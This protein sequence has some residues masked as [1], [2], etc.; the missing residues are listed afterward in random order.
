MTEA[1]KPINELPSIEENIRRCAS[2]FKY[3]G[4][5]GKLNSS[6]IVG[7]K[8][9]YTRVFSVAEQVLLRENHNMAFPAGFY[10]YKQGYIEFRLGE[11]DDPSSCT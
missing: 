3:G 6:Q 7:L 1:F 5:T 10:T 9:I 11:K 8:K 4:I 2:I